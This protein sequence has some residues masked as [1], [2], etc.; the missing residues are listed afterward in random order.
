MCTSE[1]EPR[2]APT[3]LSLGTVRCT[4]CPRDTFVCPSVIFLSLCLRYRRPCRL[5]SLL[6]RC[7]LGRPCVRC[8]LLRVFIYHPF[9]FVCAARYHEQSVEDSSCAAAC[10]AHCCDGYTCDGSTTAKR[11]FL[12]RRDLP[13]LA[14]GTLLLFRPMSLLHCLLL[15]FVR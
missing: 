14:H 10:C 13:Q 15:C 5:M 9:S 1:A 6:L 2:P 8:P 4:F 3:M 7:A 11:I 12:V